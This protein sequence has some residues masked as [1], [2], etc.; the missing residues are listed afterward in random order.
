MLY[1]EMSFP[2]LMEVQYF[3]ADTSEALFLDLVE[4]AVCC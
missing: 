3:G 4:D 2:E 1:C